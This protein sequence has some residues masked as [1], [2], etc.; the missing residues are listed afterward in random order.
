MN[1]MLECKG[2]KIKGS[3]IIA[4]WRTYSLTYTWQ[5]LI[6]SSSTHTR[7]FTCS[8]SQKDTYKHKHRLTYIYRERS[9]NL[10]FWRRYCHSLINFEFLCGK[11]HSHTHTQLYM[12]VYISCIPPSFYWILQDFSN[13]WIITTCCI[14]VV[15]L[16]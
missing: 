15:I 1:V 12:Y 13:F 4:F 14:A 9:R 6:F 8:I 2:K 11:F 10:E 5:H 3:H 7:L 16:T